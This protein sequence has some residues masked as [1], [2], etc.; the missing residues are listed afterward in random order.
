MYLNSIVDWEYININGDHLILNANAETNRS[1]I[2]KI[3]TK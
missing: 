1:K 2:Y 3:I